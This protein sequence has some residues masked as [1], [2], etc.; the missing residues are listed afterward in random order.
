V[1]DASKLDTVAGAGL[2]SIEQEDEEVVEYVQQG[3]R[4]GFYHHGR[5]ATKRE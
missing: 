2:E 3:I 1:Y 4:S 5:Y